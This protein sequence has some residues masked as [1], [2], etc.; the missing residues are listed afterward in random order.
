M[1]MTEFAMMLKEREN[2]PYMGPVTG[3]VISP[4]PSIKV[5]V[6]TNII[7]DNEDLIISASVLNGYER[8]I[9]IDGATTTAASPITKI[10]GK[11]TFNDTLKAGDEV[12]LLPTTDIQKY[13][14]IDK[15]VR[16]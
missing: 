15:A 16:L 4:P 5:S 12:I 2:K 7:L 3:T 14:L 1:S 13:Y 11:I 6:G 10:E 9:T 8:E